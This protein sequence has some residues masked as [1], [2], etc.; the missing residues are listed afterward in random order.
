M[1]DQTRAIN[2]SKDDLR[3]RRS[4]IL[5]SL[6]LTHRQ[7]VLKSMNDGLTENERLYEKEIDTIDF[8]LREDVVDD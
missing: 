8:L 7:Y 5:T 3:L 6:G 1:D 4:E 2:L